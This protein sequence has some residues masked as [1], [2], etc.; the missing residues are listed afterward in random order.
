MVDIERLKEIMREK[1]VTMDEA[2]E[3]MKIHPSTLYRHFQGGVSWLTGEAEALAKLLDMDARTCAEVFL[4]A[5][6]FEPDQEAPDTM[7]FAEKLRELRKGRGK[8]ASEVAD[9]VG[10]VESAILNYE[11]GLRAP[12]DDVKK[13]LADY[14]GVS[15]GALFFGEAPDKAESHSERKAPGVVKQVLDLCESLEKQGYEVEYHISDSSDGNHQI[16]ME[17]LKRFSRLRW[18]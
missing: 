3:A 17:A 6:H 15:V 8:T 18:A 14:Y 2:A 4:G 12:R 10:V 11:N 7:T 1:G 9:A 16:R 5:E 13:R